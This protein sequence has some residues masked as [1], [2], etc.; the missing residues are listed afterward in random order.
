MSTEPTIT[1][2]QIAEIEALAQKATPGRVFDRLPEAGGGIK[3]HCFGDD[4]SVVLQVDH[5]NG[6]FGFIGPRGEEDE[7]FFLACTPT[8]VLALISRLRAA[9]RDAA[10]YR[11]LREQNN[12]DFEFAVVSNPHFDV[13]ASPDDLDAAIDTAMKGGQQ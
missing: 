13:F 9:E 12:D 4:G 8:A 6:E 1:D 3:Y 2:E 10:R 11:W 5:K 7:R